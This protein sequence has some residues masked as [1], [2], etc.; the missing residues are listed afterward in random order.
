MANDSLFARRPD[1]LRAAPRIPC[2]TGIK[3]R[4]VK[5]ATPTK[6]QVGQEFDTRTIN[7]S[8]GG[9]LLRNPFA[10][11]EGDIVALIVPQA[12]GSVLTKHGEVVSAR[13]SA[14]GGHLAGIRFLTADEIS[15]LG[16]EATPSS[17]TGPSP[18]PR[19]EEASARSAGKAA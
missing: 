4:L 17:T 8:K 3:A 12:D 19:S 5:S 13:R 15:A 16:A 2:S 11:A 1:D 9:S 7:V 14:D 10:L 6:V 18:Q